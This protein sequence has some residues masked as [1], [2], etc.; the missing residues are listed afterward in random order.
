MECCLRLLS[1]DGWCKCNLQL[2]IQATA[3]VCVG[4]SVRSFGFDIKIF[5]NVC[6]CHFQIRN[7]KKCIKNFIISSVSLSLSLTLFISISASST[8]A[9]CVYYWI[10]WMRWMFHTI[11]SSSLFFCERAAAFA[12]ICVREIFR[13]WI[14]KNWKWWVFDFVNGDQ[15]QHQSHSRCAY[16]RPPDREIELLP[17]DKKRRNTT[18]F[19]ASFEYRSIKER[20]ISCFVCVY[21]CLW[22]TPKINKLNWEREREKSLRKSSI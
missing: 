9:L 11:S 4:K 5:T 2:K 10:R 16:M 19:L 6:H 21:E 17:D 12:F 7:R 3:N 22:T 1:N 8:V 20:E 18:C 15:R 14:L 13:R